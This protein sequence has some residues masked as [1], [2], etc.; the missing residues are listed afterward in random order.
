MSKGANPHI[1]NKRGE[2]A[3]DIAIFY[4]NEEIVKILKSGKAQ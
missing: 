1:K 2:T 4:K 3:L